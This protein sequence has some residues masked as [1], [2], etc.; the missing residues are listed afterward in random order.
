MKIIIVG[1]GGVGS[2]ICTQ[3][4]KENHDIT[5]IDTDTSSV[6]EL[7]NITD[8]FGIV[9][10]GADV[11]VLK[12]AE[13]DDADLL[14]AVTPG[15][16]LNLLCCA[17]A[18]KLGTKHTIA[19]VRNPEYFELMTLMKDDFGLSMTVNPE[20]SAAK[21]IYRTLRFPTAAKVETFKGG[22]VELVEFVVTENSPLCGKS[23]IDLRLSMNMKFLVCCVL[24]DN[25]VYIPSGTFVIKDGDVIGVTAPDDS[26]S[27]FFKAI[28]AF[29]RPVKD[30]LVVGGGRTTYY[31]ESLLKKGKI[32]ST[33]IEKDK[34]LC[35]DI[36]DE[37]GSTVVCD[38]GM[39]QEVLLEEGVEDIDAF[40]ALSDSDEKNS[41]ISMYARSKNANKI[42][43]LIN[44]LSFVDFFKGMGLESIVS[45]KLLTATE[46]LRYVRSKMSADAFSEIESLYSIL[47]G[48]AEV[49]E[50]LV[51]QE[52]D[53]ITGIPLKE[54]RP[55]EGVLVACI[56][57]DNKVI[58]PSGDDVISKG[59]SVIVITAKGI[60]KSIKDI[61]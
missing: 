60:T 20:L 47:G 14:I 48:R 39:K 54:L 15:D 37:Y 42:I 11:S 58:I 45:P 13:A 30:V 12:K 31:L 34:E 9:G 18:K 27:R 10:N 41:I 5:I 29:R 50:F 33:I 16:E 24:R 19:R 53:G 51:K 59:D 46:I 52:T 7:A 3:L 26:I 25:E 35:H 61:K 38:D 32:N 55:R 56:I 28:G 36:A 44:E 1:V 17:A 4:S 22:R 57:H 23:L 2:A 6:T 40:L 21:E 49:L 43:A 8:V